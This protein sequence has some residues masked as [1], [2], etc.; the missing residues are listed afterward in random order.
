M[1]NC[2]EKV[3][4]NKRV[5]GVGMNRLKG[6]YQR[7]HARRE[8][9]STPTTVYWDTITGKRYD[10]K[11][12]SEGYLNDDETLDIFESIY[13][14]RVMVPSKSAVDSMEGHYRMVSFVDL[15]VLYQKPG[16]F[17]R[18]FGETPL[19]NRHPGWTIDVSPDPSEEDSVILEFIARNQYQISKVTPY[20]DLVSRK[21]DHKYRPSGVF[22]DTIKEGKGWC[23]E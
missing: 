13:W 16:I 20:K 21:M 19:E 18:L 9:R 8:T 22:V 11:I 10:V 14:I 6:A 3:S 17:S 5:F 1:S 4:G 15:D 2:N 12:Y 23:I 7:V